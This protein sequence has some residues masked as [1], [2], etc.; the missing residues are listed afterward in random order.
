MGLYQSLQYQFSTSYFI[1]S[2]VES[3]IMQA[4]EGFVNCGS[5]WLLLLETYALIYLPTYNTY[6]L[7]R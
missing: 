6:S 7:Y 5:S 4:P 3:D 2:L 1:L